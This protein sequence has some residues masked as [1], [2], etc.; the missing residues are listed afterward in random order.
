MSRSHE[1]YKTQYSSSP[2]ELHSKA[3]AISPEHE[4]RFLTNC[5]P[6]S[7]WQIIAELTPSWPGLGL[8][9]ENM[10][11][12]YRRLLEKLILTRFK[13]LHLSVDKFW[14]NSWLT[15]LQRCAKTQAIK[16]HFSMALRKLNK[17]WGNHGA[18]LWV[19]IKSLFLSRIALT[20][21]HILTTLFLSSLCVE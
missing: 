9:R 3:P 8:S 21:L 1:A 7:F 14:R 13:F 15:N 4:Q 17:K 18:L 19:L 6:P 5:A 12:L 2:R 10:F 11:Y 16:L 20:L